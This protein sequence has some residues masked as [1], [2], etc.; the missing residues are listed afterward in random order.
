MTDLSVIVPIYNTEAF[1][2]ECLE[3]ILGQT[4]IDLEVI[5]VN[6]GSTDRSADVVR[7]YKERDGRIT[8][9]YQPNQGLSVARNIGLLHA[10]GEYVLF[11]DS[12]DWLMPRSMRDY[13]EW[14]HK[15]NADVVMGQVE[16]HE[17]DKEPALWPH[18]EV[19]HLRQP[20]I[21]GEEYLYSI[22]SS[23]KFIPMVYAYLCKRMMLEQSGLIF[24]PG[25][26]HKD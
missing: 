9:I 17:Q 14:A 4:G 13:I 3:S 5:I 12:D 7:D 6:D 1:I 22:V 25:L 18:D 21:S 19:L 8:Y 23:R 11:V 26:I 24:E 20:V 10:K 16:V 2:A 15:S